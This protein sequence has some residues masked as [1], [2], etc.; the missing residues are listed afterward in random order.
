MAVYPAQ[1]DIPA[2]LNRAATYGSPVTPNGDPNTFVA[3]LQDS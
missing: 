3:N 2:L 1:L